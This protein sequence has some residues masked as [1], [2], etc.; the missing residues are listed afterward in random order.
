VCTLQTSLQKHS[1][2]RFAYL[3]KVQKIQTAGCNGGSGVSNSGVINV[4]CS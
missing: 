3:T 2:S 4:S 1:F